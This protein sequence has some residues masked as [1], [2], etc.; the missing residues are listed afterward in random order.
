[1]KIYTSYFY[2]IR[3]FPRNLIPLST[4]VWDPK[5]YHDYRN[6]SH[7]YI[8]KR[9]IFVGFRAEMFVP[10]DSCN[11]LCL[12]PDRPDICCQNGG[13]Y[14]CSFLNTYRAQL[15]ELDFN[16]VLSEMQD[17]TE[18]ISTLLKSGAREHNVALIFHEAPDNPCSER[19]LVQDWFKDH[20]YPIEEFNHEIHS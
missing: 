1:M 9:G 19:R 15:D 2:Q 8:D 3:N 12:G 4:A 14:G 5:W 13:K 20:D 7:V 6:A 11:G 17:F 16:E 18:K 10:D